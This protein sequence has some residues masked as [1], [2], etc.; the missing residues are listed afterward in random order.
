[1][2]APKTIT[3]LEVENLLTQL[4]SEPFTAYN[5]RICVR[6]K[7]MAMLMLYAG[8]RVGEVVKLKIINLWLEPDPV[9]NIIIHADI[10]KTG[11][12]RI[13]PV[14]N[15]LANVF[16][17]MERLWWFDFPDHGFHNAFTHNLYS[18]TRWGNDRV[19]NYGLTTRQVERLIKEAANKAIGRRI[20][21]HTLRHT[22]AT[23]LMRIAPTRVVQELLGHKNIRSTQIYTHPN[24]ED[25]KTAIEAL[26]EA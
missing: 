24:H 2:N 21:P 5:E 10:S 7:C 9:T 17:D 6:N 1:M 8:L 14:C 16:R 12:E 15:R 23:N 19:K 13:I 4:H 22:F 11:T 25:L 26:G 18:N 3:K 20:T